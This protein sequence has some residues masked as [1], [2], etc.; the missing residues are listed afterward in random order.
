MPRAA[1][2]LKAAAQEARAL[3]DQRYET[4][5]E[6]HNKGTRW[7][8]LADK[9]LMGSIESASQKST[10]IP[11]MVAGRSFI[12]PTAR[13]SI[14]ARGSSIYLSVATRTA[15]HSTAPRPIA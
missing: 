4:S 10:A 14:W 7:F 9:D 12:S 3:F 11:P 8:L 13:S 2:I 6:P 1:E 15:I 5:Y